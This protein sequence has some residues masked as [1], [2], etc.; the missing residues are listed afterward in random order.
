MTK[1]QYCPRGAH[2]L[3][4]LKDLQTDDEKSIV[5]ISILVVQSMFTPYFILNGTQSF[6]YQ[7]VTAKFKKRSLGNIYSL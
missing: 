5:T 3:L 4:N 7:L 1:K 6:T 2:S